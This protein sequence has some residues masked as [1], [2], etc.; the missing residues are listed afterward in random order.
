[1]TS[2][3][4]G[5]VT[6]VAVFMTTYTVLTDNYREEL[7]KA[8]AEETVV[9][10]ELPPVTDAQA[11][12]RAASTSLCLYLASGT[13]PH[14]RISWVCWGHWTEDAHRVKV[15]AHHTSSILRGALGGDA[16]RSTSGLLGRGSGDTKSGDREL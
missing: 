5:T 16:H 2:T 8:Y 6:A 14:S 9:G 11:G 12:L 10:E 13:V 15:S 3:P 7:A 1:M 4:F